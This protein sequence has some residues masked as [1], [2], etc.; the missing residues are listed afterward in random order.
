MRKANCNIR[1]GPI[2]QRLAETR[3]SE[4]DRQRALDVLET[5]EH[6]A[7]AVLWAKERIASFGTAFLKPGFKN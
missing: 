3:M 5:A 2:A 4:Y 6:V 7:N 1:N